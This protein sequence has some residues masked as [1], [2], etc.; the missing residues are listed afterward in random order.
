M[1]K[2]MQAFFLALMLF[3]GV[4]EALEMGASREWPETQGVITSSQI[5]KENRTDYGNDSHRAR[6]HQYAYKVRVQY[7]YQVNA[8]AYRGNRIQIRSN[9]HS[10]ERY[11]QRE[12]AEYPVGKTVKVYYNPEEPERSVLKRH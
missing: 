9:T 5:L 4:K 10:S 8:I 1:K 6:T 12:L 2:L 3:F 11:A 7:S